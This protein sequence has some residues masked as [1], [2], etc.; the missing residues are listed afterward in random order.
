MMFSG[1]HEFLN[2]LARGGSDRAFAQRGASAI[3]VVLI[4]AGCLA[5]VAFVTSG[6]RMTS[7]A[8]QL[9]HATD[10]AATAVA[11]AYSRDK[12]V[13]V[14]EMA[15]RYVNAN[16]GMD[17]AQ[18]GREL[19]VSVEPISKG[20]YDG[21]RVTATF[22]AE[23][24]MLM[25]ESQKVSVASAAVAVYSPLEIALVLPNTSSETEAEL[26][27]L[28][29]LAKEF[30]E[31]MI[32]DKPD[33]WLALVPYSQTVNVYDSN[34]PNRIRQWAAS[35]ALNPVE[36]TSLF[37]D[38]GYSISS[39]ASRNMPDLQMQLLA[40]YRG[41]YEGE[42]YFWTEP[43]AGAFKIHY[44][45]DL[46][47]NAP[48]MP[49]IHWVGPNP[50]FGQATGVNDTRYIVADKGCPAAALLPLTNDM[51]A[52]EARLNKMQSQ[53]N[54]NYAIAMGWAGMALSPAFRGS[55]GWGDLEHPRD[56][57]DDDNTNLKAIVML[58]N[59]T[60]NWFDTD[61]Y[62]S[63]VGESTD[64]GSGNNQQ[65]STVVRRFQN[66][67]R[68]FNDH[69]I[70]FYFIGVRPGDPEDHG[71]YL[72]EQYA[73]E[74]LLV[75]GGGN[76]DNITFANSDSFAGGEGEI[77]KKLE[78]IAASLESKSSFVRLVE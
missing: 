67:C 58:A 9:K 28:R 75:C 20:D 27:V 72:F 46:P 35:G 61:A 71:R 43:P 30:A 21:F 77:R 2:R 7:D 25:A 32:E 11:L 59:T 8:A 52:I 66:L 3:T 39:L 44:R 70:L 34:F 37:R 33:R 51:N 38:N 50:T 62:N 45:A 22:V 16:L 48:S 60:G 76:K 18:L 29:R 47:I 31:S 17:A 57:S 42:N 65:Y 69:D 36:L 78:R 26:A 15:E 6:T 68:S 55:T 64:D 73:Y 10:A 54:V 19:E 74:P 24:S 53:F 23:A 56:F 4:L 14:Q 40:V 12:S 49:Y 1:I 41:L 63:Y 13:D 5:V